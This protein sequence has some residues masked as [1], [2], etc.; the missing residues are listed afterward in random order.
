MRYARYMYL[1]ESVMQ[2]YSICDKTFVWTLILYV[3]ST[4]LMCL[5]GFWEK[6]YMEL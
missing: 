5:G 6:S 1:H 2:A 3:V 4:F